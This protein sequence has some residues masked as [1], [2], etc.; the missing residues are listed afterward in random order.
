MLSAFII[1]PRRMPVTRK[2]LLTLCISFSM[3]F[4]A[5]AQDSVRI[6]PA[7][8]TLIDHDQ[9]NNFYRP[10][11][12]PLS[13]TIDYRT[14]PLTANEILRNN[15]QANAYSR[16]YNSFTNRNGNGFVRNLL[17]LQR[18]QKPRPAPGF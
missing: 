10:F 7:R 6:K 14:Y 13:K 18:A 12:F 15:A 4:T 2:I 1:S 11:I 17:G 16:V 8:I 5:S 3:A 9:K